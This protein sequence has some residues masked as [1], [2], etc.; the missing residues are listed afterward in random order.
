MATS[1]FWQRVSASVAP[2]S[3]WVAETASSSSR[4]SQG[5]VKLWMLLDLL[6]VVA[7]AA[8][9]T[10]YVRHTGP[11]VGARAF[12]HGTLFNGRSMWILLAMLCGFAAVLVVSSRRMH[13]YSP[14]RLNS[15][16]NEQRLTVQVCF[17][18]GLLLTG[19]LYLVRA[20]DIPRG[21]VILTLML[22]TVSLCLRRLIYRTLLYRRF[23][24]GQDT[25]N[26]LI[27]GT[28]PEAYALRHHLDSIRHLGYTFKGF[29][30]FPGASPHLMSSSGDVVGTL[31][32]LF[33][34]ARKQFV[35]EIFFTTPCERSIVQ[36]V[37]E[38]SRMHGV[39][40]RVVPDLYA[41]LAWNSPIEYI[42]Q[43]PTIP[44]HRGQVPE[45][46]FMLKRVLDVIFSSLFFLFLS[47][48]LL[49]IAIAIKLESH[50]PV[51][52]ASERIGK[53][54]RIF[55]CYKFRT[56][57]RD[58]EKRRTEF[59]HMNERD[60]VLFKITNDPRITRIGRFLR[61]YSLDELPQ[62]INVLKGDMS[63]VGPR[64][65]IA[66][67]VMEYKPSHLRR[68]DVTPG[69][70]GL[71]QVQGRR[72]PS[73]DSY[74]SLDVTYI[75]SWSLWLDIKIIIRTIGVVFSG[76]GT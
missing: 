40:L 13:L 10:I 36:E 52:Y 29:I 42:G 22:V 62:F 15:F 32:T 1:D 24:R 3:D 61:K 37:L 74:V 35:D 56:M 69:I 71:W 28:G 73:F 43:F 30:E 39:D 46:G 63:V 67:E 47:P 57:V 21:I 25:R 50:G 26:V 12:Y 19:T 38:K 4:S 11:V 7:S 41:G 16:L 27:V 49:V 53:K 20:E 31:D 44:L 54:G 55:R 48:F 14:E 59:M 45:L 68:L 60:G 58:A 23:D 18:S 33:Q 76:T 9:A 2:S 51:F 17:T 5:K 6:T 75:E 65:P 64:P 34:H 8:V 66:S 72:D 70:T